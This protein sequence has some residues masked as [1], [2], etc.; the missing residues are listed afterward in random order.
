MAEELF[1][2]YFLSPTANHTESFYFGVV[3]DEYET[4]ELLHLSIY[5]NG[6][7]TLSITNENR[8]QVGP[9]LRIIGLIK[10]HGIRDVA[11]FYSLLDE[12]GFYP[13]RN[14]KQIREELEACRM[15]IEK[16]ERCT[17]KKLFSKNQKES[18]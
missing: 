2:I 3:G 9:C 10:K 6:Y 17:Y 8:R 4:E 7:W 1:R 18:E 14:V 15:Q 13:A 11:H 5:H 12:C 16:L